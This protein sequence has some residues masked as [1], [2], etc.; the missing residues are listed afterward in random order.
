MGLPRLVRRTVLF[1][2]CGGSSHYASMGRGV[3]GTSS[4]AAGKILTGVAG[5]GWGESARMT[6]HDGTAAMPS[7]VVVRA[8][9]AGGVPSLFKR[10]G[11]AAIW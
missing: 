1:R 6:Q 8:G 4:N 7:L 3:N 9:E 11:V 2:R 10:A 5:D